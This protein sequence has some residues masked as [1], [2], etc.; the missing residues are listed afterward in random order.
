MIIYSGHRA[1]LTLEHKKIPHEFIEFDLVD[2][3]QF[4][5]D[6]YAKAL[7]HDENSTG[8]APTI[9]HNGKYLCESDVVARYLDYVFAD[10]SKYGPSLLPKDAYQR[11][12]VEMMIS[13]FGDSGW[14][15]SYYGMIMTVDKEKAD[16]AAV[17]WKKKWKILN[18]RL[19]HFS[20]EGL[21]L[22]GNTL[23]LFE[24]MV[25]PFFERLIVIEEYH[26]YELYSKWMELVLSL[27]MMP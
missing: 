5:K 8:K 24:V 15:K 10:E 12:G 18:E 21:Y 6:A 13:W 9:C 14:L 26:K 4:I 19:S 1:W 2:K 17:E 25:Y 23:S 3:P 16:Q 11:A 27:K 22:P 7:G 20:K